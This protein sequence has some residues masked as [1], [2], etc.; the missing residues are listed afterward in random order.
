MYLKICQIK[1]TA[2]SN[3]SLKL[4]FDRLIFKKM[5]PLFLLTIVSAQLSLTSEEGTFNFPRRDRKKKKVP[6]ELKE[7]ASAFGDPHFHIIRNGASSQPDLCFDIGKVCLGK[8]H[9][10]ICVYNITR[11]IQHR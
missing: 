6:P 8:L 10:I 4:A 11:I 2:L 5:L 7:I 9:Y 1:V 3:I